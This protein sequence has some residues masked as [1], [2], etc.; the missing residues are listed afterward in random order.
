MSHEANL[1]NINSLAKKAAE[2]FRLD[3]YSRFMI[4]HYLWFI[5]IV[6]LAILSV[7]TAINVAPE[8]QIIWHEAAELGFANAVGRSGFYLFLRLLDNGSQVFPIAFVLGII[9]AEV[10]HT[11][12]G[13]HTMVR[14]AGMSFTRGATALFIVTGLAMPL[15]FVLDNTI[16]PYAFMTLSKQGLGEYGWGYQ[17]ARSEKMHWLS[18]SGNILQVRLRDDPDPK[19]RKV[20]L[21][22]FNR[23]G[24]LTSITDSQELAPAENDSD[25]WLIIN[26]RN[27]QIS[28]S[29]Q[30]SIATT[31][32][33]DGGTNKLSRL[34]FPISSL[35]LE[36]R[37]IHPK[38]IPLLDLIRLS[39]AEGLPD[40]H[41]KYQEWLEI[42][43]AQPFTSALLIICIVAVFYLF[44]DKAGLMYAAGIMLVFG[45][46]G[47]V[48]TRVLSIIAQHD[49]INASIAIW[50]LP[51]LL[52]LLALLLIMQ[53]QR[54]DRYFE[55]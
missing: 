15:Q 44:Y 49:I 55:S 32:E 14:A 7:V 35:W 48:L 39:H 8:I 22:G 26:G 21:Y 45:Y 16:R 34:E 3:V 50:S 10:A 1:Q 13:R 4:G 19:F 30:S 2:I 12:G 33:P 53:I 38:Y 47:F 17:R 40:N 11:S 41:P 9:W 51:I 5:Q 29:G 31:I 27:W 6:F 23:S 36:Y 46:L 43:M 54:R 28:A 52:T 18:F 25:R 37:E 20:T 42:R 24:D